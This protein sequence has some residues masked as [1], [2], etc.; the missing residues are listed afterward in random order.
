V[1]GGY[2]FSRNNV[3][4]ITVASIKY[5]RALGATTLPQMTEP[6]V[7]SLDSRIKAHVLRQFLEV[8]QRMMNLPHF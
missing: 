1:R 2:P 5:R 4:D 7:G 6:L 3:F 8:P